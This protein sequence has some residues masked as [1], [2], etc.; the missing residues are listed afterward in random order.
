MERKPK[1]I[2]QA[3]NKMGKMILIS[4]ADKAW[5]EVL[6]LYR[7]RDAIEK[8]FNE[9]KNELDMMPLRVRKNETLKGLTLIYFVSMILRSL[10]LQRVRKAKLLE[11]DSIEGILLDMSKIRAVRIGNQWKLTEITKK[12]R[13]YFEKMGISVPLSPET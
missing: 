2:T 11:K 3:V 9:L 13:T 12:Q 8:I 10:L 4:S 1:A 6:S 7:E 5:D